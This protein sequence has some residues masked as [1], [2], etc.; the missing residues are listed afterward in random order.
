MIEKVPADIPEKAQKY[1]HFQEYSQI[2][3]L[4]DDTVFL[5]FVK[6]DESPKINSMDELRIS[7]GNYSNGY[8]LQVYLQTKLVII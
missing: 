6:L 2:W 3:D 1:N 5:R 4:D 8:L 7:Y